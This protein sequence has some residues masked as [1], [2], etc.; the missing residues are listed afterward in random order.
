MDWLGWNG[1]FV[2]YDR[3]GLWMTSFITD[4]IWFGNKATGCGLG[5]CWCFS[6]W[7]GSLVEC[8]DS[9]PSFMSFF[10]GLSVV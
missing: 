1:V 5:D 3:Y 6:G 9:L 2:V 7:G 4:D 8:V 10:M